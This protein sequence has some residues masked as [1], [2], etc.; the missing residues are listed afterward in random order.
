MSVSITKSREL[1]LA[2]IPIHTRSRTSITNFKGGK[3]A[4]LVRPSDFSPS[5]HSEWHENFLQAASSHDSLFI[6][7]GFGYLVQYSRED[8]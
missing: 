2:Y 8:T 7:G 1:K 3:P 4:T 6:Y 5:K